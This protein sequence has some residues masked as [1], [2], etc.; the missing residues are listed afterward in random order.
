[1]HRSKVLAVCEVGVRRRL[2]HAAVGWNL[3]TIAGYAILIRF[4]A[5]ER[6]RGNAKIECSV[7]VTETHL[8][9]VSWCGFICDSLSI[10]GAV[11][12]SSLTYFCYT[13]D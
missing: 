8:A 9:L 7:A 3:S 4:A 6:P 5:R 13:L 12:D 11:L 10:V 2:A 1:M